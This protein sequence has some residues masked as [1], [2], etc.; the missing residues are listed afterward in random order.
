MSADK[1]F[2][3]PYCGY[4]WTPKTY[5]PNYCANKKCSKPLSEKAKRKTLLSMERWAL[6]KIGDAKRFAE[7]WN[8]GASY[9]ELKKEFKVKKA[10]IYYASKALN[11]KRRPRGGSDIG[12]IMHNKKRAEENE[13]R[14]LAFLKKCG[15]YCELRK[16][17]SHVPKD[18]VKRLLYDRRIYRITFALGRTTGTYKRGNREEIFKKEALSQNRGK[19]FICDSRTSVIRLMYN[20]LKKPKDRTTQKILSAFLRRYLS[21]AEKFA[22]LWHLGVRSFDTSRVKRSI[23]IDGIIGPSKPWKWYLQRIRSI[24]E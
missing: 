7:L 12:F 9:E 15:G 18:A 14:V 19:T 2:T 17:Y 24:D 5:P 10:E 22:V 13:R 23:Q 21:C 20:Y 6:R 11:L 3:C 16:L 1:Q 8:S 4:T